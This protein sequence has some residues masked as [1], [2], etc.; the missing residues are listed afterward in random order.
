MRARV[1]PFKKACRAYGIRLG[2]ESDVF[3]KER[4]L[5]CS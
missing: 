1:L 3:L 2:N 4:N 5:E